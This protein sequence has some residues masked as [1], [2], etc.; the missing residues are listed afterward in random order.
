MNFILKKIA[1]R[2]THF[3]K[4]DMKMRTNTQ[5]HELLKKCK[6]KPQGHTITYLRECLESTTTKKAIPSI[7]EDANQLELS[8]VD[9]WQNSWPVSYKLKQSPTTEPRNPIPKFITQKNKNICLQKQN[10][11]VQN[12]Y[13]Y[14]I[15]NP[16]N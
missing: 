16:K 3:I 1:K 13:V 7:N 10:K 14:C 2:L 15:H 12:I 8:Y 11:T 5:H 4:E 6:I 9:G